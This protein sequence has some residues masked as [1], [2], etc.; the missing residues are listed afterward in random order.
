MTI[1]IGDILTH[2]WLHAYKY[3]PRP[4]KKRALVSTVRG[5]RV[6]VREQDLEK[7]KPGEKWNAEVWKKNGHSTWA[8]KLTVKTADPA[9]NYVIH[10]PVPRKRKKQEVIERNGAFVREQVLKN[11]LLQ[12]TGRQLL[13]SDLHRLFGEVDGAKVFPF[14]RDIKREDALPGQRW[15]LKV[16]SKVTGPNNWDVTLVRMVS[17]LKK[18]EETPSSPAPVEKE[19][20]L[21]SPSPVKS[22]PAKTQEFSENQILYGIRLV[23]TGKRVPKSGGLNRL[24]ANYKSIEL[25]PSDAEIKR[26]KA[27]DGEKW[28][29][30]LCSNLSN[31]K[32]D[33]ELIK[34][35][36]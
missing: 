16:S 10:P 19:K 5:T 24:T 26:A 32:W 25:H 1:K 21:P 29:V 36:E 30:K 33:V 31:S 20:A 2:V 11:V 12:S 7:A 34:K 14:P 6:F 35:S 17:N 9:A 27:R 8:I 15:D 18:T 22:K 3:E 4:G 23:S 28:N 13:D